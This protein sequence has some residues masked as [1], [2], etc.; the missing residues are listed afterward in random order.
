MLQTVTHG[1]PVPLFGVLR[2]LEYLEL[3][4]LLLQ[5]SHVIRVAVDVVPEK[6]EDLRTML[7]DPPVNGVLLVPPSKHHRFFRVATMNPTCLESSLSNIT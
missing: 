7:Q 3:G 2:L 5:H 4:I 6:E 1:C